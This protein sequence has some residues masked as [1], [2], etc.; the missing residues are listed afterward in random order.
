MEWS[1]HRAVLSDNK[2]GLSKYPPY[3]E[4]CMT[5]YSYSYYITEVQVVKQMATVTASQ[6]P[7]IAIIT[8]NYCEK[9]AVDAM[10][11]NKT[12]YVKYKTGGR[13]NISTVRI[14]TMQNMFSNTVNSDRYDAVL[15]NRSQNNCCDE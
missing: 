1:H 12:T 15:I 9:L 4:H 11:Q 6:Q 10:M 3:L 14:Y 8:A 5:H 7:T 13:W 2:D